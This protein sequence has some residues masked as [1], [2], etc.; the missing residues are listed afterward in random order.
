M[1][2]WPP[3]HKYATVSPSQVELAIYSPLCVSLSHLPLFH[4]LQYNFHKYFSFALPQLYLSF[5]LPQ[6]KLRALLHER[7]HGLRR[8]LTVR[9]LRLLLS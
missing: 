5:N 8:T 7:E 4:L 6:Q 1:V 3:I 9:T 2:K